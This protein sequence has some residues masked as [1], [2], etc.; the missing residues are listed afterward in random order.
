MNY[1]NVTENRTGDHLIINLDAI[2]WI[3]E[4]S[5]TVCMTGVHG[6]QHG[7]LYFNGATIAKIVS[8]F[9]TSSGGKP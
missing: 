3:N 7:L 2:A 1:V 8:A 6:N 5:G 9:I 4:A